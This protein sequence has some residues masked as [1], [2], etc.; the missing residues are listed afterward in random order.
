MADLFEE[1][2]EQLR[3]DRYRTFALKALPWLLG[4]AAAALIATLAWWGWS[5]YREQAAAKAS[6]QYAAA[7]D[8]L[9]QGQTDQAAKL[10]T[11]VSKSS[12]KGYKSLALMQLGGLQLA[13]NQTGP[14]VQF[15]DQSAAAAPDETIG[16]AA[17][18]K[19]A[20]AL[21]DTAP[22]KDVEARLTPLMQDGRP[23]RIQARE[24]LAFTKLM[25]GD[26]A[27]ARGDFVI[28]SGML[29]APQG[30]RVRAKAAMGLI[31]S[32]SAKA[33]A[34]TVHA[35]AALPPT[36]AVPALPAPQQAPG[37]Q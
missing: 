10:F 19:S 18:L 13:K 35:A 28:I 14:A 17:R 12:A 9:Q 7:L 25:A 4:L 34:S 2:E 5:H 22:A 26:V 24:A 8:A 30:A 23:Y 16:D 15:F 29:D 31:D 32:G 21:L 36:P 37:P 1:V 3:S 20:F 33:L 27:G 6:E 11:D